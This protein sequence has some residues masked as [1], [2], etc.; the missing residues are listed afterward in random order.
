MIKMVCCL[1]KRQDV[2]ATS[3]R[4]YCEHQLQELLVEFA[5]TWGAER[6]AIS[7]TLAVDANRAM[8]KAR[9]TRPPYDGLIEMWWDQARNFT[10]AQSQ[11]AAQ[12]ADRALYQTNQN[13]IDY[14]RSS[15]FF[16]QENITGAAEIAEQMAQQQA[17]E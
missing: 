9:H 4:Y 13:F 1:T 2:D 6:F 16:T 5:H 17:V 14:S 15:L 7:H 3:F 10:A 12:E 11:A 8:M